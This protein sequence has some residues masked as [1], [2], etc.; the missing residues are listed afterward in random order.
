MGSGCE[1]VVHT[2]EIIV[3]RIL[4]ENARNVGKH[5]RANVAR[6]LRE[7]DKTSPPFSDQDLARYAQPRHAEERLVMTAKSG[8]A[9]ARASSID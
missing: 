6:S 2:Y 3:F 9:L 5:R 7:S 1:G 4:R 8:G